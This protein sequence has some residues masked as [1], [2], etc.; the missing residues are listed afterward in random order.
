MNNQAPLYEGMLL[1]QVLPPFL[2]HLR[3]GKS[4]GYSSR[5]PNKLFNVTTG[6]GE[7]TGVC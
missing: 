1:G 4:A 2:L 6:L 5:C 7:R 3:L